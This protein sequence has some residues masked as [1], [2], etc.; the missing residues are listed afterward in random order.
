M[1]TILMAEFKHETDSFCPVP[2]DM[3]AYRI[4]GFALGQDM[5]TAYRGVKNEPGAFIDVFDGR[6]D[7]ELIPIL[8]LNA[9][10][11]G[12]V[13]AEVYDFVG[14]NL[15]KA[16]ESTPKI[17]GFLFAMHGAMVAEGHPDGE[18]DMLEM[19]RGLLG[20]GVPIVVSLD[21]HANITKKMAQNA[22]VI[23][24]YEHYPHTDIYETALRAAKIMDGILKGRVKPAL[25]Y[26]RV[27]YLNP[28]FPSAFPEIKVFHDMCREYEKQENVLSCRLAHGFYPA[29][30]EEMGM[31]VLTVTNDD[32]ALAQ[33]ISDEAAEVIWK[34]RDRLKRTFTS[35][36]DALDEAE[37]PDPDGKKGPLVIADDSDNPGGG[38]LCDTTHILHRILERKLT[39]YVI[40]FIADPASAEKCAKAGIGA[41]VELMLGGMSDPAFSGGPLPVKGVVKTLHTGF[42]R[43]RDEMGCGVLNNLGTT[44]V[45]EIGGNDV[46]ITTHRP[47]PYD[48]EMIRR[49]GISPEMQKALVVKSAVHYRNSYGKF[50][51]KMV[52]VNLPGYVVP[53]PDG[54]PFKNWKGEV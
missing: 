37:A 2:A 39:G 26:A 27:P 48:A 3:E 44:A 51:R 25:G 47:Q 36:D 10:P 11:S 1:K 46:I 49:C 19:L 20:D 18:G 45:V 50:A 52:D 22:D 53:V 43:N 24:P 33:Q 5:I 38:G 8:A 28:M 30:I 4:R 17:D 23:V 31:S 21:L 15:K 29:D 16:V 6:D 13:T 54:L 12:P 34:G 32:P 40:G 41:E 14:E 35:L 7:V 9:M 42:Y